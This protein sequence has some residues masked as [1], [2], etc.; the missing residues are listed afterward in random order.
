MLAAKTA[1]AARFDALGEDTQLALGVEH[2]AYLEKRLRE[3][4]E[5]GNRRV[6]GAK[7]KSFT[8]EKYENKSE[9]RQYSAAADST[10]GGKRKLEGE[11]GSAEVKTE[12][13]SKK[14]KVEEGEEPTEETPK[15]KKKKSKQAAEEVAMEIKEEP[16]PEPEE[17]K[18]KKK[19]KQK[20]AADETF[21]ES[22]TI[23][24]EVVSEKK[25]KKRK[26]EAQEEE[27][28]VEAD[29]T[30]AQPEKKKKKKKKQD[31]E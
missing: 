11:N 4:E 3:L 21:E 8:F 28:A 30:E 20:G 14:I 2:K 15:K 5:G 23:V 24:E 9:I 19:K 10:F 1:L 31:A 29:E 17:G 12:P 18:K 16:E 25:K 26:S 22:T 27:A 7:K 6:S 13:S